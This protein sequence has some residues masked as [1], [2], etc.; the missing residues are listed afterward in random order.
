MLC[1]DGHGL[2]PNL[3]LT[4]FYASLAIGAVALLLLHC[5]PL[6]IRCVCSILYVALGSQLLELFTLYF[7][8]LVFD[9]W[10]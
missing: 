5:L 3:G 9:D 2:Y 10:L 8:G 7:V 6:W 1:I 4:V